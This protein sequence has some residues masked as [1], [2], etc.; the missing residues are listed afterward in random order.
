MEPLDHARLDA[1][2]RALAD[3][4]PGAWLLVG[5]ALVALGLEP[6][7]VTAGIDVVGL[8]GTLDERSTV[9]PPPCSSS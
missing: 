3:R 8:E 1:I 6:R 7:Q 4:L 9:P 2:L 5:G